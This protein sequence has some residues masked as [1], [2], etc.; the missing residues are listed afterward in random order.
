M[1]TKREPDISSKFDD[2]GSLFN[3]FTKTLF[4]FATL[5]NAPK[6]QMPVSEKDPT[7]KKEEVPT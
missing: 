3:I 7:L 6:M 4:L 2:V 5:L 1:Q